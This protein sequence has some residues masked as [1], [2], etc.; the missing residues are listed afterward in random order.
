M[1][2]FFKRELETLFVHRFSHGTMPF[3]N[4][5]KNPSFA[6]TSP[7]IRGTIRENPTFLW[8]SLAVWLF[9]ELSN[10]HT[11]IALRNLRPAGSTAR[12]IPRGYGFA[13][14][15]CPNYFFETVGWTVIAVMTGS[16]AA[17]L[18]LA[19]STYQMVVWAVK[20]HRN[21]KKEFGKAYP[22]NRKAM[23]PFIL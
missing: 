13:L 7:Y 8:A 14:V 11:H 16:Y 6:A 20:K 19:V 1:L 22:A 9:A 3:T 10:L 15:S 17:W 18:F 23:F 12:A 21:Y 5:F 4:V 2:H